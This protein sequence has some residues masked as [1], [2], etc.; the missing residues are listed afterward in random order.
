MMK[1]S[2]EVSEFEAHDIIDAE[3]KNHRLD[4][5]STLGTQVYNAHKMRSLRNMGMSQVNNC[6][7]GEKNEVVSSENN[8]KSRGKR[9]NNVDERNDRVMITAITAIIPMATNRLCQIFTVLSFGQA[10]FMFRTRL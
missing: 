10:R 7:I 8:S 9:S 3:V 4:F 2:S 6:Q 5:T 1:A